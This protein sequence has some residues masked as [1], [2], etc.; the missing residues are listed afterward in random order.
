MDML[1]I[2]KPISITL[3]NRPDNLE[4]NFKKKKGKIKLNV[5]KESKYTKGYHKIYT[6]AKSL[7]PT[8]EFPNPYWNIY[9]LI[10]PFSMR[11]PSSVIVD[12]FTEDT[13][14]WSDK[15]YNF[16]HH[17]QKKIIAYSLITGLLPFHSREGFDMVIPKN[18][19][20]NSL[21][22]F[23]S[24]SIA[25]IEEYI[26]YREEL[27]QYSHTDQTIAIEVLSFVPKNTKPTS[28]EV[29]DRFKN[30]YS[31]VD[32][33]VVDGNICDYEY[34]NIII[35]NIKVPLDYINIS[36]LNQ[37]H[38]TRKY[39]SHLNA[40]NIFNYLI[41][42][43]KCLSK[44]GSATF[45]ISDINNQLIVDMLAIMSYA[46]D[47]VT[48]FKSSIQNSMM[49]YKHVI[50]KGFK[51]VSNQIIDSMIKYSQMW[52]VL[53][54]EC[55]I[56]VRDIDPNI[57]YVSSVL[58]YHDNDEAIYLFNTAEMV[59]KINTWNEIINTY[60]DIILYGQSAID[61][62]D[63]RK[64]SNSI[65]FLRLHN[66]PMN[67][68]FSGF[69]HINN[70][71]NLSVDYDNAK[72][73]WTFLPKK[74]NIHKLPTTFSLTTGMYN[75]ESLYDYENQL[76][77][78]KRILDSFDQDKYDNI[79]AITKP[80]QLLKQHIKK[81][82]D[83]DV[84]QAFIKFYEIASLYDLFN[85]KKETLNSFHF[86]EAPGQFIIALGRYIDKKSKVTDYNWLA[87]SFNP[88][89]ISNAFGDNYNLMQT[90]PNRWDFGADWSGDI[91]KSKNIRY[92]HKVNQKRRTELITSDCGDEM[93][94]PSQQVYQD[95]VLS[96]LNY[97][98]I[99]LALGSL[100]EGGNYVSKIF[101]PQTTPFIVSL[102]YIMYCCFD[103]MYIHKSLINTG[104][105]EVYLICKGY[106]PLTQSQLDSLFAI[107]ENITMET[108]L[109]DIP[110]NF[111][112][113]YMNAMIFFIQQ[114]ISHIQTNIYY[115]ENSIT[116]DTDDLRKIYNENSRKWVKF[117]NFE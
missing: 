86:C 68:S 11:D 26:L 97:S 48:I 39:S 110:Q 31:Y 84:S 58:D 117:F 6:K 78:T 12:Y 116:L 46:F 106:H 18:K 42:C 102:N 34:L 93:K 88:S 91:R 104:S 51:N 49:P 23:T 19:K 10:E 40:Q 101:L 35:N 81:I 38:T 4:F 87:Q 28:D 59:K 25:P 24:L 65:H 53:N 15:I 96:V 21:F 79:K 71:L 107:K 105:S 94:N 108:K 37:H 66:I 73:N 17:L 54:I 85:R 47:E 7:T 55:N 1:S 92:Y 27:I 98:Q 99:L 103:H 52:H 8:H 82:A 56:N 74:R 114:H 76:K 61:R 14:E 44:N 2:F 63:S 60:H 3:P 22:V 109:I 77:V 95:K 72:F 9:Y 75:I 115:Y 113:Q 70:I 45:S 90:Y 50:C 41:L 80:L 13:K 36:S 69:S 16:Q 5:L 100:S 20:I 64:L 57:Y 83:L 111:L 62:L 89:K 30:V 112:N 43:F 33:S 29:R 32:Y 67:I